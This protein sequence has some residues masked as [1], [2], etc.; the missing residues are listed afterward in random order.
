MGS[1]SRTFPGDETD[2]TII[3]RVKDDL[4]G[5]NLH[6]MVWVSDHGFASAANRT[7]LTRGGGHYIHAEKL[8]AANAGAAAAL[9]RHHSVAGNLSR[10]SRPSRAVTG[11]GDGE[12]HTAHLDGKWLLRTSDHTLSPDLVAAYAACARQVW[13]SGQTPR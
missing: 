4:A 1:R 13:N 12:T 11:D 8:C 7:Y 3:R 9:A 5:W 2:T 10:K 6:R